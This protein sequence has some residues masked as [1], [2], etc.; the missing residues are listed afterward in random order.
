MALGHVD[1]N[2]VAMLVTGT[3]AEPDEW[4]GLLNYYA[5]TYWLDIDPEKCKK[6]AQELYDFGKIDQPRLAGLK[7]PDISNGHWA[8]DGKVF[9]I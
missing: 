4:E 6:I 5:N 1:K 9:R 8:R 7:P 3:C 2:H